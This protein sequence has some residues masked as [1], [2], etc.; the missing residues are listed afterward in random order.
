MKQETMDS[1]YSTLIPQLSKHGKMTNGYNDTLFQIY[2]FMGWAGC[3]M[4]IMTSIL[5]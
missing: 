5:A 3:F 1:F 2:G 4:S